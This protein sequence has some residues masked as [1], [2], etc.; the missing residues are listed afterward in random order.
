MHKKYWLPLL[1]IIQIIGL[2][3]LQFFPSF[4]ERFYSNGIYQYISKF[5]RIMM[6]KIPFSVG[7]CLY[8]LLIIWI[9]FWFWK[10]RKTWRLKWKQHFWT[11]LSG[12]S[13]FYFLFHLLWALNYYREPLFEK[14]NIKRDYSDA[15]LL[16][17]TQK[18][19]LKTNAIQLQI[20]NDSIR[21][22]VFPFDKKTAY[23]MTL[24]GYGILSETYPIFKYQH[25]SV[26]SSLFSLPLT[27]MGFSGY[28]NPFSNE[29]QV[30]YL[31]PIYNFPITSC[32]EMAHQM[33]FASESECNFIGFLAATKNENIYFK[34]SAYSFALRYCLRNWEEK[35]PEIL[36]ELLTKINPGIL[37][38]YRENRV[39]WN[40]YQTPI[41]KGFEIFYDRFLK[42]NQ[43]KDGMEG[44]SKFVDLLIN[45][46]PEGKSFEN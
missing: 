5:S 33:G 28:L 43:Q 20:T 21:K 39:F 34:Y 24:N 42:M 36:K 6:S 17:F 4:V 26:K 35:N 30:N 14:M 32:H 41:E 23:K 22:V 9:I 46:Y 45:F 3:I 15:D 19:I 29:A 7:D 37:E 18:L 8:A 40:A 38:N 13:V 16:L 27:Y 44:Y 1:L 12:L 25:L 31:M 10:V 2:Q 11:I